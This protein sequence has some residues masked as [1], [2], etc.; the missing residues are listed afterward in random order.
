MHLCGRFLK[1]AVAAAF[2]CC[3]ASCI[4]DYDNCPP[5]LDLTI[6]GDWSHA[7][8]AN[9][10]GMAYIFFPEDGEAAWRFDFPGMEAGTV[11]LG[12]GDYRFLC[13][14]D[15]TY[16]VRFRG[17]DS[18][19][20]YEAYTSET[21]LVSLPDGEGAGRSPQRQAG[22]GE[23]VVRA[24]DMM[25]GCAYGN[26]RL[27]YDGVKYTLSPWPE[28]ESEPVFSGERVLTAL[29]RPLTAHYSCRMEDVENLDG[30]RW[31]GAAFSGVAGSLKLASGIKGDYPATVTFNAF[32]AGATLISGDFFTF[33][34]PDA[35]DAPNTLYLFVVLKDGRRFSYE[36]NVTE[37]VR[38]AP[39]PMNVTVI[40]KGLKLEESGTDDGG[41]FDVS[42]DGWTTVTININS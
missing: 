28:D 27:W 38:E 11:E 32:K 5:A 21:D 6:I 15:D 41:A 34:V 4:Y 3:A 14:N 10:E 16:N 24:P 25:W 31:L 18:Y 8:E 40:V 19:D 37:Q 42:V 7:P 17:E 30:V 9:P 36:F 22:G 13:F 23:R 29:L 12:V 33:G 20:D 1:L 39:D 26:F 35:P 2:C